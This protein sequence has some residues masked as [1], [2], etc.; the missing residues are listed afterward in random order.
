[1]P[2]NRSD[3][4]RAEKV[5]AILDVAEEQL[6]AGGFEA[7]SM[8]A[9]ARRLGVAQNAVYWYFP[10]RDDVLVAVAGRLLARAGDTPPPPGDPYGQ[11]VWLFDRLEA[12][13]PV[14]LAIHARAPRSAVVAQLRDEAHATLH[15]LVAGWLTDGGAV[16]PGDVDLAAEA[17]LAAGE[18]LL[19]R[20]LPRAQR[21]RVLR[22]GLDRLIPHP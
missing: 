22:Y 1:V 2:R 21:N 13:A 18:G 15:G 3:V 10:S 5:D 9:V 14:R 6:L 20:G 19:I 12:V 4:D 11:A 8:A 7:L 16:P 17:L